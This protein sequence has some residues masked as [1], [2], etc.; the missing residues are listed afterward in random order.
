MVKIGHEKI[1][2]VVLV[3]VTRVDSHPR[4]DFATLS[5]SHS[6]GEADLAKMFPMPVGKQEVSNRV[7]RDEEVHPSVVVDVGSDHAPSLAGIVGNAGFLAYIGKCPIPV[8]VE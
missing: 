3:E 7:V 1:H 8:V 4:P 5:I 6:S 2:P